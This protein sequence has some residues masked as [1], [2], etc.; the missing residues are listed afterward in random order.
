MTAQSQA[1]L[2]RG[3]GEA[4]LG[5]A[6]GILGI[7]V[8]GEM[9]EAEVIRRQN[10]EEAQNGRH[11]VVEAPVLEGGAMDRFMQGGKKED[12]DRAFQCLGRQAPERPRRYG[13]Q[14]AGGKEGR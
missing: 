14:E 2:V 13:D 7:A 4:E 12:E 6:L 11:P 1:A 3:L 9:E 8:M 5:I 10:D